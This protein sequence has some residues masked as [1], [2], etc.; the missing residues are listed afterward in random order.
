MLESPSSTP[1]ETTWVAL[2]VLSPL[3][4]ACLPSIF[5]MPLTYFAPTSAELLT[6]WVQSACYRTRFCE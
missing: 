3:V 4:S 1:M 6:R 2:L 5:L